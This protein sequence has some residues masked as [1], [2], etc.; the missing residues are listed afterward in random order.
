M[1]H[2]RPASSILSILRSTSSDSSSRSGPHGSLIT[3]AFMRILPCRAT[4][5]GTCLE[6]TIVEH[7]QRVVHPE[8][9]WHVRCAA[10]CCTVHSRA[11][12]SPDREQLKHH[13]TH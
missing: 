9:T 5:W 6:P 11:L 2:A 13:P 12:A 4:R 10:L 3:K 8:I 1:I 7:L